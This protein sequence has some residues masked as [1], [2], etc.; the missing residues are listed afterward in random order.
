MS[1]RGEYA[2]GNISGF[3]SEGADFRLL[4]TIHAI[5][6]AAI[7]MAAPPIPAPIPALAPVESPDEP[8]SE[9]SGE[10]EAVDVPVDVLVLVPVLVVEPV[11]VELGVLVDETS[12]TDEGLDAVGVGVVAGV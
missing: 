2:T 9:S 3:F 10:V 1:G 4:I 11:D 8:E 5:T 7:A 12:S 6:I